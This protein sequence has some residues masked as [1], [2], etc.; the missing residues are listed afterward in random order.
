[1]IK[2]KFSKQFFSESA[3]A[4][5][6]G[7][8]IFQDAIIGVSLYG[9]IVYDFYRMHDLLMDNIITMYG[10][11]YKNEFLDNHH[12][13]EHIH[14]RVCKTI[15]NLEDELGTSAPIFCA[16]KYFLDNILPTMEENQIAYFN[17]EI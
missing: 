15:R 11:Y 17:E 10:N 12:F 2:R 9:R 16:D 5:Y 8:T 4:V 7:I 13:M 3:N 1:M 6:N 14:E